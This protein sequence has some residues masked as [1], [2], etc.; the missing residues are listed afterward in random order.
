MKSSKFVQEKYQEDKQNLI[1]YYNSLGYRDVAI[2][3]DS[4]W[5][6]KKNN[7]EINVKLKEGKKYYIGDI[8]FT[9]NTVY[10]T[11]YLQRILGY[12]KGD[13]YDAVGF[14]KKVGEDGGKEDDSDIKSIYM[15]N[16]YLFS[17]VTPV[18]KSVN[19]DAINLEIRINEGEQATW[20]KVTW[21]GNTTTHDHVILRALT[22]K[23]GELFM[24]EKSK[25]LILIWLQCHSLILNK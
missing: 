17:N 18:E 19:G 6:N 16:G 21:S 2:V 20:N 1:N 24:K 7:F 25:E 12:K 8:T 15:N 22:T 14:N 11:E 9:G 3:S 5:R 13:I 10:P 23:P 4:V